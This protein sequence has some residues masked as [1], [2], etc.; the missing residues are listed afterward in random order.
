MFG[1]SQEQ[2]Y[3]TMASE[4][5]DVGLQQL[6]LM[7]WYMGT[8]EKRAQFNIE[9]VSWSFL[10]LSVIPPKRVEPNQLLGRCNVFS[11]GAFIRSCL[12]VP[13]TKYPSSPMLV[14]WEIIRS[15]VLVSRIGHFA[16]IL[17]W[18]LWLIVTHTCA[19]CAG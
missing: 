1:C 15:Y 6:E 16:Y 12:T 4:D 18:E 14:L 13:A 7:Q 11:S 8:Q 5:V 10:S 9:Q 19:F 17:K 3:S 2:Q